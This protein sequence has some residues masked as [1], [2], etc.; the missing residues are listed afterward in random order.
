MIDP[1]IDLPAT[2][3]RRRGRRAP[4][5]AWSTASGSAARSVTSQVTGTARSPSSR[6]EL[7][8]PFLASG[9]HGHGAAAGHDRPAG[10]GTDAARGTGDEHAPSAEFGAPDSSML[11]LRPA[12]VS[13]TFGH[14]AA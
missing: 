11:L 12:T 13:L 2:G 3:P 7:F 6:A 14:L 4:R 5:A 8:E 1:T 9:Q 10:G